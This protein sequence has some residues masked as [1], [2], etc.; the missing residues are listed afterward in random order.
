MIKRHWSAA[1]CSNDT[2]LVSKLQSELDEKN[3]L[4]EQLQ[5]KLQDKTIQVQAIIA[6]RE[7][8]IERAIKKLS[9]IESYLTSLDS[10]IELLTGVV[11]VEEVEVWTT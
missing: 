8:K 9:S 4:V 6:G 7:K 3:A 2:E 1:G 5:K 11:S 10:A